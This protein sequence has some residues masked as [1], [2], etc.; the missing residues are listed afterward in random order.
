MICLNLGPPWIF[1][2]YIFVDPPMFW[3][4][5]WKTFQDRMV[6]W[7]TETLRTALSEFFRN[8]LR[9]METN[10]M[11]LAIANS[12]TILKTFFSPFLTAF[13]IIN[14]GLLI[15]GITVCRCS[16]NLVH[17]AMFWFLLEK[18]MTMSPTKKILRLHLA[19][20]PYKVH[21]RTY[22]SKCIWISM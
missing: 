15:A 5:W 18:K 13:T 21:L 7:Q 20:T 11:W 3:I 17:P 4:T 16:V 2:T 12:K 8:I 14:T 10:I 1:S 9:D 6:R 19:R 22:S